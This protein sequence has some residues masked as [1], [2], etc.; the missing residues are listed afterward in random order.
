MGRTSDA[1]QRLMDAAYELIWEYSYGAVTIEAICERASV[2]KGSF[3]YFFESKSELATTAIEAW[4]TERKAIMDQIFC[5]ENPPLFRL[6]EYFD[7]I[8]NLQVRS[9]QK[10]GHVLGCPLHALGVEICTQDELIR[11]QL[12][13]ILISF[14]AYF[15]GSIADA[16]KLRQIERGDP[17]KKAR[18]LVAYYAGV[19][20]QARIEKNLEPIQNLSSNALELIGVRPT[21]SE[22]ITRGVKPAERDLSLA[23]FL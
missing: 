20:S 15:E 10:T 5:R 6:R 13:G 17:A 1:R 22:F 2:K 9:Y 18:A 7:F 19:M 11:A 8:T 23:P 21:P 16:Q 12:H 14:I 3:Y 4:W